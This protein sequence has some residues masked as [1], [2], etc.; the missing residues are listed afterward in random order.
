MFAFFLVSRLIFRTLVRLEWLHLSVCQRVLD[1]S[2]LNI[3]PSCTAVE[4]FD[5]GWAEGWFK[6]DQ[7][8]LGLCYPISSLD[9]THGRSFLLSPS[10]FS[11]WPVG[12][13]V[14]RVYLKIYLIS[15]SPNLRLLKRRIKAGLNMELCGMTWWT[16]D[17][18]GFYGGDP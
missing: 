17:I 15:Y 4:A 10:I 14:L 7:A 5:L 11:L 8:M 12:F 13:Q 1:D 2:F 3:Y 16:T 18:G 6:G 9:W